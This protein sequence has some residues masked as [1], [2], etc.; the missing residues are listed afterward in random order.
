MSDDFDWDALADDFESRKKTTVVVP[1]T[2]EQTT[3]DRFCQSYRVVETDE[4]F[5][6]EE[7]ALERH[8]SYLA[9]VTDAV[10]AQLF[11]RYTRA[12][13]ALNSGE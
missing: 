13:E 9:E 7:R 5:D 2:I 1:I 6:P 4:E 8:I 11:K 3:L 10:L 12:M